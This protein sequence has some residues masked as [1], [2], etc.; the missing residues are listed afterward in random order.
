M[1][2]YI[3]FR[4]QGYAE[5]LAKKTGA[6]VRSSEENLNG[7]RPKDGDIIIIDAHYKGDMSKLEGIQIVYHLQKFKCRDKDV[8]FKILSWYPPEWFEQKPDWIH[9]KKKL[10]SPTNVEFI[11]LPVSDVTLLTT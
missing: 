10:F 9:M 8:K 3:L 4:N 1:S 5:A 11:Q 2:K 6:I 7:I